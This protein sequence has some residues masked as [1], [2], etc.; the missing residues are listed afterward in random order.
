MW[1][2]GGRGQDRVE[3]RV[4]SGPTTPPGMT[5]GRPANLYPDAA[6]PS[7]SLWTGLSAF[8]AMLDVI[9]GARASINIT[10]W[11]ANPSFALDRGEPP[12]QLLRVLSEAARRHVEVRMLLWAGAP[13][14]MFRPSRGD[15]RRSFRS[16]LSF[17]SARSRAS[18]STPDLTNLRCVLG[19]T[20]VR[21][22]S[23]ERSQPR[24][25]EAN[26]RNPRPGWVG[27]WACGL[28]F[29]RRG[30]RRKQ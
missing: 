2:R 28:R 5:C 19:V 29:R 7:T 12:S 8:A 13:A 10:G 24:S 6:M 11:H 9:Q 1:S 18:P 22:H 3:S 17:C 4:G 15:M 27:G 21:I 25:P 14:P 26:V 20:V 23:H 16:S 30:R